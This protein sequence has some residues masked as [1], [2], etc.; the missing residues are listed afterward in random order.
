MP[1]EYDQ[2][3]PGGPPEQIRLWVN[4]LATMMPPRGM[5]GPTGS[6]GVGK[7]ADPGKPEK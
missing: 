4:K 3:A 2:Y 5:T 6:A 7:P 1:Y